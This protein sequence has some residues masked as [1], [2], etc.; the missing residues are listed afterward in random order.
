MVAGSLT[1]CAYIASVRGLTMRRWHLKS[2]AR[3][4][5]QPVQNSLSSAPCRHCSSSKFFPVLC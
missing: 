5:D 2:K 1:Y 4:S 3:L